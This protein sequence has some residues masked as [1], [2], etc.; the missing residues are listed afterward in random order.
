MQFL[1]DMD[2]LRAG[3]FTL[4][5]GDAVVRLAALTGR[6]GIVRQRA[7][8]VAIDQLIVDGLENAGDFD[9]LRTSLGAVL[10]G[11]AG[12]LRHGVERGHNLV[13]NLVFLS[14]QGFEVLHER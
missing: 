7:D 10:A 13:H 12:N 6:K 14:R 5:A 2:V 1:D 3:S 4:T 11:G 9:L 8:A